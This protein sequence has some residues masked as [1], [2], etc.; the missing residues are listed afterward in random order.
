M[1]TVGNHLAEQPGEWLEHFVDLVVWAEIGDVL[2]KEDARRLLN[3]SEAQPDAAQIALDEAKA[4]REVIYHLFL[5]AVAKKEPP[6]ADLAAFNK[7]LRQAPPRTQISYEGGKCRWKVPVETLDGVLWPLLWAAA[8]LL[9]SEQLAQVKI[10]EGEAC[11]W[12]FLDTSRNQSRRWC[13][14]ADCGNRAKANRFYRRHKP[15]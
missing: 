10:C 4:L 6:A 11:G 9:V 15:G 5:A 1:N 13:S 2:S 3:E 14:M 12:L 7:A 8:D